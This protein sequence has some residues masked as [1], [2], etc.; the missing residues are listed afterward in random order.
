MTDAISC[1]STFQSQG[2]TERYMRVCCNLARPQKG[3]DGAN[4]VN[5]AANVEGADLHG[6][7]PQQEVQLIFILEHLIK[8]Q[9]DELTWYEASIMAVPAHLL[10]DKQEGDGAQSHKRRMLEELEKTGLRV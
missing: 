1:I 8:K 6:C 7:N 2:L 9:L 10:P 4:V 3:K 5:L